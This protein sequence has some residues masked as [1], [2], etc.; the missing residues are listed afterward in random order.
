MGPKFGNEPFVPHFRLLWVV[1]SVFCF[2]SVV[3]L[4]IP[5]VNLWN[6]P[7]AVNPWV[8]FFRL[9]G[10][11]VVGLPTGLYPLYHGLFRS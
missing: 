2:A 7:N 8:C 1:E 5:L 3:S 4:V 11:R 6:F 10:A 9:G